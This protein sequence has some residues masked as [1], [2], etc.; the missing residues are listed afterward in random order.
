MRT[1]LWAPTHAAASAVAGAV[2]CAGL[3]AGASAAPTALLAWRSADGA[4]VRAPASA[5]LPAEVPLGSVW[6]LFAHGYLVAS[7]AN[8]PAYRCERV[9]RDSGD[10]GDEY[11]CDPGEHITRD[12]ALQRSCG[13]Y[14]EPKRLAIEPPAW[15]RFWAARLAPAWLQDVSALK[16][17]TRVSVPSLL[18]ALQRMPYGARLA[19]RQALLPNTLRD[20]G[21]LDQLGSS[22]RFKTWSWFDRDAARWGGAA[23]WLAD[24]TPFWFGAAGTG[25]IA[26]QRHVDLL[27]GAWGP[28]GQLTAAPDAAALQAQPCVV[29]RLFNRYPLRQVTRDDGQPA[30]PGALQAGRRYTL[31]FV[32]GPTLRIPGQP[33]LTLMGPPQAP[34][35][36]ARLPLED[37]I[38]RV[39]DREGDARETAAAR[40]LAIAARSWLQQN[41]GGGAP[42]RS[43][44]C[45]AVDDDSRAQRV[46]PRPPTEAARAVAAF[47][48]GLVLTGSPVHYR[49]D[50]PRPQ[51]LAWKQAVAASRAGLGMEALLRDAFPSAVLA[52]WDAEGD[53]RLLP[54]AAAW[55]G[56]R[57]PRWRHVLQ[58][59]AGY[60][61]PDEPPQVCE[62][63][64]GVP[65]TDLRRGRI[66]LREWATR[67]GRATLIHE[68]LHLAFRRHPH[69]QDET[70]IE[71]LAQR[72]A[73]E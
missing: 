20:T 36:Q 4:L 15:R 11:C 21:M 12:E 56:E 10:S 18:D 32:N 68:Y 16:P 54:K 3:A 42:Q 70:Y 63:D 9:Q 7:G 43:G 1:S 48:A 23:G 8:E 58:A 35:L 60:E 22:P 39:V 34:R 71:Q 24:G 26:L 53:C 66:H 61:P 2:L 29:V 27:A 55:L 52:G 38:A 62:L 33:A 30:T 46:S 28:G 6:K 5:T 51:V 44:S 65:Y 19:A 40:A 17:D 64:Q 25:R 49:L 59:E 37:Y 67:D 31:A 69:G 45:L 57:A 13:A 50:G 73:D 47:T 41:G 72:L 14:F